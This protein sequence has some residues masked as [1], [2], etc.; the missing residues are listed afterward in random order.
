MH[1]SN[2]AFKPAGNL[3][4]V[5]V[6][7]LN[8]I[9]EYAESWDMLAVNAKQQHP[10]MT[11][12]WISAYLKTCM[13]DGES[14]FCLFA[15][16]NDDLVGVLPLL[17][18][19]H[20]FLRKKYLM[21]RTPGDKHTQSVDFLFKEKYGNQV[22]KLFINYLGSI[23]PKVIR[24]QMGRIA[25]NSE[26]LKIIKNFCGLSAS[27][28]PYRNASII[29]I[30]GSFSDFRNT[31]SKKFIGNIRRSNN[32]LRKFGNISFAVI[33]DGKESL[34]SF[35]KFT[36]MEKSG[37]K[38][39]KG[40]SIK[41]KYWCFFDELIRNLAKRKWLEWYFLKAGSQ[42]LAA[43]MT[44]PF[45]RTT[46]IFKTC[47]N[48]DFRNHSPG[49]VLT[50]KMLEYI[51]ATGKYNEIN[52]LSEF[53]WLLRWKMDLKPYYIITISF[54]NPVSFLST[55]I[56]YLLYTKLPSVRKMNKII[57]SLSK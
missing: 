51:F 13:E 11:H 36:T 4:V 15:F 10:V 17:V 35:E 30:E 24:L 43:Y 40:S 28:Y 25:Y 55:R 39:K 9:E 7:S 38:G 56:P 16:E 21:L 29:R 45:G 42:N 52:F 19:E 32:S 20:S 47:F 8:K 44:I 57:R 50:D 41:D 37:W 18:R 5:I 27:S 14:W 31:L 46:Y 53:K 54:K 34:E 33:N 1:I 48:E 12:A 2:N 22:I 3:R 26:T 6:C 49:V 23:N